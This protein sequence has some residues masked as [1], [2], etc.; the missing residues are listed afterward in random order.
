M[1]R[2][3][4][5]PAAAAGLLMLSGV[6]AAGPVPADDRVRAAVDERVTDWWPKPEEKRFDRIGWA[7]DIRTARRLAAEHGRPVF[8]FTMDGRVNLGRC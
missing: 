1:R 3:R 2:T 6:W 4:F 7:A 5:A 8:L